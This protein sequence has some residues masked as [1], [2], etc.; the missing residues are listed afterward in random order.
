MCVSK[1]ISPFELHGD[2]CSLQSDDEVHKSSNKKKHIFA[3]RIS[4]TKRAINCAGFF[5]QETVE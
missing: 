2:D 3:A 1:Y 4:T 5:Q